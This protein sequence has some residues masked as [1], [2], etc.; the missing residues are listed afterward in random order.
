MRYKVSSSLSP[1]MENKKMKTSVDFSK[2]KTGEILNNLILAL[3]TE[4]SMK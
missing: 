2:A 4:R 1:H 3:T